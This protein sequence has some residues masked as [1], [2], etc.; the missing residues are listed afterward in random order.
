MHGLYSGDGVREAYQC[1]GWLH[2][3]KRI[4]RRSVPLIQQ[5]WG[6]EEQAGAVCFCKRAWDIGQWLWWG[7][8]QSD[9]PW[10]LYLQGGY[11][12]EN[13]AWTRNCRPACGSEPL[14]WQVR[15]YSM[16]LLGKKCQI[17]VDLWGGYT[18][19]DMGQNP[20][21]RLCEKAQWDTGGAAH[22]VWGFREQDW[23]IV[24]LMDSNYGFVI[25]PKICNKSQIV[26][27]Y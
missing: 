6:E 7:C 21:Q 12:Q 8:S 17:C 10:R 14:I 26:V 5:A 24:F 16:Y 1:G 13:T 20:E 25:F 2:R 19:A 23:G 4:Y 22:G 9:F 11:I 3:Q 15:L 27:F 18:C